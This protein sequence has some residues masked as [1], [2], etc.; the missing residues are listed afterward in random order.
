MH[1]IV[2]HILYSPLSHPKHIEQYH[3]DNKIGHNEKELCNQQMMVINAAYKVLRYADS[4]AKYDRKRHMSGT[5][6]NIPTAGSTY[7]G[8]TVS[9]ASEIQ[10]DAF[11]VKETAPVE[12]LMDIIAELVRDLAVNKGTTVWQDAMEILEHMVSHCSC[13]QQSLHNT[14]YMRDLNRIPKH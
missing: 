7:T 3:P 12:S 5:T 6:S 9:S 1:A 2:H 10:N 11:A 14:L 4:R 8:K 13:V